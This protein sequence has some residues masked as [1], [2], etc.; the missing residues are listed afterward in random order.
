MFTTAGS[1]LL[2]IAANELDAGIGSGTANAVAVV[3]GNPSP[4][5]AETRPETTDPIKIPTV[6]VNAT[7]T[8]ASILRRRAQ[9]KSS[10]T[11]SPMSIT[12]LDQA[13]QPISSQSMPVGP[14]RKTSRDATSE[15]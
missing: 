15:V 9:L 2:T 4:F 3:P 7:N 5:I 14:P 12:P 13:P 11:C 8:A 1:T 6:S 10:L